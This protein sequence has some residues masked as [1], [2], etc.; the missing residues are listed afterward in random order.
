MARPKK[1]VRDFRSEVVTA[2]EAA[3]FLDL[4]ERSF[5]R[6]VE[7]GHISKNTDGCYIL[8]E[9][10]EAYWKSKFN[11][12]GLEAAQTRWTTAKAELSELQLAEER[13]ELHR[14]AA[15]MRVWADNVMNAKTKLLAIPTKLAP[16][17]RGKSLQEIQKKL[18]TEINEV[19]HELAEYDERRIARAAASV[20]E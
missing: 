14:A 7:E 13:G 16:E 18:K 10:S 17:L 2:A 8:G 6:L 15:V 19:L 12:E 20:R 9:I 4:P 11:T 1:G 5:F 3:A